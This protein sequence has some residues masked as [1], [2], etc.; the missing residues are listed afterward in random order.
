MNGRQEDDGRAREERLPELTRVMDTRGCAMPLDDNRQAAKR[1]QMAQASPLLRIEPREKEDSASARKPP[2]R[3]PELI[4]QALVGDQPLPA[5]G[6]AAFHR[7]S[8]SA[9]P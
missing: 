3:G 1:R 2:D 4:A 9:T 5:S 7:G 8:Y 6:L